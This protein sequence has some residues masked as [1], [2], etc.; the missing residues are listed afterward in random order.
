MPNEQAEYNLTW[1]PDCQ[2]KWDYDGRLVS[3][4]SRYWPRGGGFHVLDPNKGILEGN[5]TRTETI[6]TA[7][8]SICIGDLAEGPYETIITADFCGDTE[9]HVKAQV[10]KWAKEMISRVESA[11]R[12]EFQS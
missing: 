5:E 8:A 9:A 1:Q 3:L 2:G 7:T 6:P 12:R 4:S 11:I 10:E